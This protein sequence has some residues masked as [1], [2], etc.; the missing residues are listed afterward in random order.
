MI[1]DL[2]TFPS[3]R[4]GAAYMLAWMTAWAAILCIPALACA[5]FV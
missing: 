1:R 5:W 4:Q 3:H 2:F